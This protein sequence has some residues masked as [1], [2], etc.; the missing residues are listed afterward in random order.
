MDPIPHV[1]EHT[2]TI[3]AELGLKQSATEVAQ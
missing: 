2:D 1:G 3:L